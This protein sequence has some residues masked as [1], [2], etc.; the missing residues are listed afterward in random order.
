MFDYDWFHGL[1][2]Q[3]QKEEAKRRCTRAHFSDIDPARLHEDKRAVEFQNE[4]E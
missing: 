2:F 4:L 3:Q 1:A